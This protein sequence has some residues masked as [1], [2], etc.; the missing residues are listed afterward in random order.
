[1][2]RCKVELVSRFY[3]QW[4][5]YSICAC[6]LTTLTS[7]LPGSDFPLSAVSLI[8]SKGAGSFRATGLCLFLRGRRCCDLPALTAFYLELL[9]DVFGIRAYVGNGCAQ[10][11]LRDEQSCCPEMPLPCFRQINCVKI[12]PGYFV[13]SIRHSNLLRRPMPGFFSNSN[14]GR[15]GILINSKVNFSYKPPE[16]RAPLLRRPI[17]CVYCLSC[18]VARTG[19]GS[20]IRVNASAVLPTAARGFRV[21][22]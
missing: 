21:A 11:A 22:L 20:L 6:F 18:P 14:G 19:A 7:P 9:H 3:S 12:S 5:S 1:M 8:G 15:I 16:Y 17:S 13:G 2:T 10:F 4:N